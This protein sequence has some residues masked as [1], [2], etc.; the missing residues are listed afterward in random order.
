VRSDLPKYIYVDISEQRLRAY[1]YGRLARTF[2]VATGMAK[3]PT[4]TG[5]YSILDK[6]Y[7][8]NYRWTYG[9]GNPDNYDL[10]WVTWNLRIMPHKY[11]HY[12]PWRKVFGIRGSHGCVNVSKTDAQWIYGWADLGTPVSI[13][14]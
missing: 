8:V 3:Y 4:P 1:E 6:P 12:A 14:Q 11:I 2:L 9:P 7:K 13:Q 5:E 10:G